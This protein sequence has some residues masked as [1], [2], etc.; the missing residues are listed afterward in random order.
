MLDA[1]LARVAAAM[2]QAGARDHWWIIGSA[3]VVLH[4]V[5]TSVADVD[6][7][8]SP[9]DAE[10]LLAVWPGAVATGTASERFRS[11]P[12]A[13]LDGAPLPVEIMAGLEVCVDGMWQ[14]VRPVTRA[15][16]GEV[17]VPGRAEMVDIL[18]MFG[19]EKDLRR[20]AALVR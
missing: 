3:A 7:L 18:Q 5:D 14:A 17:V 11:H 19:R 13:R 10:R 2:A 12:Y 6:L 15:A 16:R 20:A 8:L 1:T 9:A 4:G